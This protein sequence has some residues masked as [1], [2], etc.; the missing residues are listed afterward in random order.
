MREKKGE[1][2]II[3]EATGF[4]GAANVAIFASLRG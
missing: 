2:W 1:R 4:A 3:R